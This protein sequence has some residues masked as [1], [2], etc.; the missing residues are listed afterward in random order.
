MIWKYL[1]A[2]V[3]VLVALGNS[4][5]GFR[6]ILAPLLGGGA[7][8]LTDENAMLMK[9][10]WHGFSV[11]VLFNAAVIAWPDTPRSLVIFAGIFWIVFA[12]VDIVTSKFSH[13]G[14]IPMGIAGILAIIGA[15]R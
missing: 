14:W 2:A 10:S 4:T 3:L 9:V 8:G 7:T 15:Y 1:S 11:L 13:P 6:E 5:G 12:L